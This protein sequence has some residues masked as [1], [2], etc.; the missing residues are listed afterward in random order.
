MTTNACAVD[1]S[2]PIG[3]IGDDGDPGDPGP[4]GP[5]GKNT[6]ISIYLILLFQ[7]VYFS[8]SFSLHCD[9]QIFW[10]R[11][12]IKVEE[13]LICVEIEFSFF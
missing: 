3:D 5:P 10:K 7:L 12:G 6:A 2:G 13:A 11:G 9:P 1:G 8:L 4:D